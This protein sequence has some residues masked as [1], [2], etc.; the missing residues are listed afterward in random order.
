MT[1]PKAWFVECAKAI[2]ASAWEAEQHAAFLGSFI[3]REGVRGLRG[4]VTPLVDA[5]E[6]ALRD[7]RSFRS[8]LEATRRNPRRRRGRR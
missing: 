6:R 5:L 3:G 2:R 4:T 7:A 8:E 1:R